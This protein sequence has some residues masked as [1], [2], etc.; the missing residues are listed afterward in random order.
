MS[1]YDFKVQA[2]DG[3]QVD[4]GD[5]RG[6]VLVIVNTASKCG[7]TPQFAGLESLYQQFKDRGVTVIG[8]PCNQFGNQD[9]GTNEEIAEFCQVNYGVTFP[10]M[11]KVDVKGDDADPLF[12]WLTAGDDIQWNFTKFLIGRDGEVAERFDTRVEPATM[13]DAIEKALSA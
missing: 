4:L 13:S 1:I 8:F 3:S 5:H 9:P 10:M 7:F 2:G 12:T 6:Q 11:A